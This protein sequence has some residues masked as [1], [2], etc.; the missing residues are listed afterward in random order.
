MKNYRNRHL[1]GFISIAAL[2][3]WLVACGGSATNETPV[4]VYDEAEDFSGRGR[5]PTLFLTDSPL[6][7]PRRI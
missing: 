7:K 1:L 4:A 5:P 6:I 2:S 3:C